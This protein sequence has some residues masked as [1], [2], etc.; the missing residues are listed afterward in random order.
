MIAAQQRGPHLTWS[1]DRF[2]WAIL[3]ASVL[4]PSFLRRRVDEDRLGYLF[5]SNLPLP[6][7]EVHAVY[8]PLG[9]DRYLACGIEHERLRADLPGDAITLG[10]DALPESVAQARHID[11]GLINLL[12]GPHEPHLVRRERRRF[13]TLASALGAL[14]TIVIMWGL[15]RRI[16]RADALA[17]DVRQHARTI[18]E[19]LYDPATTS[20]SVQPAPLR[21]L[22]EL[23][24][25]RRTRSGAASATGIEESHS[26]RTLASFLENWPRDHLMQ[27]ESLSVTASSVTLIGLLPSATQAQAFVEAFDPPTQWQASQPQVSAVSGGVRLTWRFSRRASGERIASAVSA[28]GG[29]P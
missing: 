13:L 19:R 3:D 2:Y 16:A 20:P 23:R 18:Y 7:D 17:N 27:T 22:A 25:L 14:L 28:Q 29:N 9:G 11:P 15:E 21:L 24:Q 5:E 12:T 26:A 6:A 10:P 4:P 8:V 1:A